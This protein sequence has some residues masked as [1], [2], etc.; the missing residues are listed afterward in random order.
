MYRDLI[1]KPTYR[2]GTDAVAASTLPLEHDGDY[3][4]VSGDTT[5][6]RIEDMKAGQ[7]LILR[8]S[9]TPTLT[10]D[11]TY[12]DLPGGEDHTVTAGE[13]LSFVQYE[14]GDGTVGKWRMLASSDGG[15]AVGPGEFSSPK[16]VSALEYPTIGNGNFEADLSQWDTTD[17]VWSPDYDGSADGSAGTTLSQTFN[18]IDQYVYY[19]EFEVADRTTGYLTVSVGSYTTPVDEDDYRIDQNAYYTGGL[20]AYFSGP[21]T[22]TITA[23]DGFDGK[24]L[25]C[26]MWSLSPA[27]PIIVLDDENDTEAAHILVHDPLENQYIGKNSGLYTFSGDNNVTLGKNAG[28]DLVTGSFNV[29][30]GKS[31]GERCTM[32]SGNVAIGGNALSTT[33]IG[34][35]NT[36]LG[37]NAGHHIEAG[38]RNILIGRESGSA[39]INGSD[40]VFLGSYAGQNLTDDVNTILIGPYAGN[41]T[42]TAHNA[43]LIGVNAGRGA[44]SVSRSIGIGTSALYNVTSGQR[45]ISIGDSALY[46]TSEGDDNIAIGHSA[47]EAVST[48]DGNVLIGTNA[49]TALADGNYNTLIGFNSGSAMNGTT[50][51]TGVGYY[52]LGLTTT[53][54]GSTAM[55][56]ES[57]VSLLTGNHNAAFGNQAS[58]SMLTGIQNTSIGSFAGAPQLDSDNCVF[59]GYNAGALTSALDPNFHPSGSIFIGAGTKPLND[60]DTNQIVIGT[61]AVGL[62]ANTTVLGNSNTTL[63]R[64]YGILDA[65]E[66]QIK[67]PAT[68]NPSADA[69]TLDDYEEGTFTPNV[70]FSTSTSGI[71]YTRQVGLYTKVGNIVHFSIEIETSSIGT[72]SGNLY[73]SGLPFS[74][75]GT[76]AAVSFFGGGFTH[77]GSQVLARTLTGNTIIDIRTYSA[78]TGNLSNIAHTQCSGALLLLFSGSYFV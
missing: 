1:Y 46:G 36:T 17:W 15:G 16:T 26:R 12:L 7:Q 35:S 44:S 73:I 20:K 5:I 59:V 2:V 55:G 71:T 41:A 52:S 48:G 63:T 74:P 29:F 34:A 45:N 31:A 43:I 32:G 64:I 47:G 6:T 77:A 68:Q 54:D 21:V 56:Y 53:A 33:V 42:T 49:G 62:G 76:Q 25:Y 3:F 18:V 57:L 75:G 24:L 51:N 60:S 70:E 10:H 69:N 28:S 66:G 38:F 19:G 61:A 65:D 27:T 23:H 72:S 67:F 39:L 58:A 8:F 22:V 50:S 37:H 11:S 14:D 78:S 9:G 40:N 4:N 30:I 13:L